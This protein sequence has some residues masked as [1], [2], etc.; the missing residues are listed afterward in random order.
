LR[1]SP[2]PSSSATMDEWRN[3]WM[4]GVA[5]TIRYGT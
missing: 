1:L 3:G 4:Q 2:E 5:M